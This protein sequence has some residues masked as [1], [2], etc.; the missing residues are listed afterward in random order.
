M[1]NVKSCLKLLNEADED[2]THFVSQY[3]DE[4][5]PMTFNSLDVS[6]MLGKI[7]RLSMDTSAMKQVMS[8]QTNICEYLWVVTA[9]VNQQLCVI[10]Q[11][12]PD[13]EDAYNSP[14]KRGGSEPGCGGSCVL[15]L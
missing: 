13:R 14:G 2:I 7:E 11:P 12:E 6:C 10:E 4:L 15:S 8:T 9:D 1:N 3:L 5:P